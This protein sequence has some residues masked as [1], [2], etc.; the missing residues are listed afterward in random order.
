MISKK[1]LT[2]FIVALAL[3]VGFVL[4]GL[5]HTTPKA[6]I[7]EQQA[8]WPSREL[9]MMTISE[10]GVFGTINAVYPKTASDS[11]TKYFQSFVQDQIDQF[12]TDVQWVEDQP[13][14]AQADALSLDITY[15]MEQASLVQTYIV[16]VASY[17]GGAH[18]MQVRKTFS[19]NKEGQLLTISNLFKNGF[20][21]LPVF[22]K[23]V[24][25]ALLKREG[26]Q[27]DWLS[28]GAAPKEENYNSFVVRDDGVLVLFDPYQVAPYVF[29]PIDV[30][31]PAVDFGSIASPALFTLSKSTTR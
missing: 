31:I 19:F 20:D 17:T 26:V 15:T 16:T 2:A 11:I 30:F 22:A 5:R 6:D 27:A 7:A 1:Q 18:G 23:V 21:G 4:L 28:D 13:D 9:D 8:E 12:K 25:K 10:K 14:S 29:G 3:I 24:Q